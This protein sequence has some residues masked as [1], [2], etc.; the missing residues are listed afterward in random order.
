[1]KFKLLFT[2]LFLS[3]AFLGQSQFKDNVLIAEKTEFLVNLLKKNTYIH[4]MLGGVGSVVMPKD[5][6]HLGKPTILL[7]TN[8]GLFLSFSGSGRLYRLEE[9][10]DSS[11]LFIRIDSTESLNYNLGANY[12]HYKDQVHSFG[13]YGFWRTTG[14]LRYFNPQ[15]HEWDIVPLSQEVVPQYYP[16][17]SSWFNPNNGKFYVSF[18]SIVNSSI[19]GKENLQGKIEPYTYVLNLDTRVWKKLGKANSKLIEIIK[20][21][22]FSYKCERGLIFLH[23]DDAY[24]V[25]FEKNKVFTFENSNFKQS[26]GRKKTTGLVYEQGGYFY[27]MNPY[28]KKTDSLKI[29]YAGMKETNFPIWEVEK[30][31][32]ILMGIAILI[33]LVVLVVNFRKRKKEKKENDRR[34]EQTN[35]KI[36][37]TDTEIALLKLL[38]EKGKISQRAHINDVNYVLGLKHKNTGL[39]KKVRSDTFN[40]INEKFRYISKTDDP[41]IQSIRSDID[42]RYFEYFINS[43]HQSLI[44]DYIKLI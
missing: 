30:N 38:I 40:S 8:N 23:F 27:S 29:D 17:E 21:A 12:F 3:F 15:D 35:Y 16:T 18:Q 43:N 19:V 31:Y 34:P 36:Q 6:F 5:N 4:Y 9:E 39:Q 44:L 28:N 25:D 41:L 10:K 7:K 22:Q 11:F 2:I 37:F 20:N 13:G 1:M 14:S 33:M 26:L 42:K 24:L 32:G